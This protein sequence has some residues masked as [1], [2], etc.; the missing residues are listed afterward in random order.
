ML[1]IKTD[2]NNQID[3]ENKS[4]EVSDKVSA[5]GA[6][7]ITAKA[8]TEIKIIKAKAVKSVVSDDGEVELKDASSVRKVVSVIRGVIAKNIE[9]HS[10]NNSDSGS[11]SGSG[12]VSDEFTY[13]KT[14]GSIPKIF[15]HIGTSEHITR[16]NF[17]YE[18]A[19]N[20]AEIT[21]E[22]DQ[23][24]YDHL[25]VKEDDESCFVFVD[26]DGVERYEFGKYETSDYRKKTALGN[27][28]A[29]IYR[30]IP[31]KTIVIDTTGLTTETNANSI[32]DILA[33]N[34]K[35]AA[36]LADEKYNEYTD[37]NLKNRLEFAGI[38]VVSSDLVFN[39]D[40]NGDCLKPYGYDSFVHYS[41]ILANEAGNPSTKEDS[42]SSYKGMYIIEK[43]VQEGRALDLFV[44]VTGNE[45]ISY[46]N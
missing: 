23:W 43:A 3:I 45:T 9:A 11:G 5:D 6:V 38:T 27:F 15:F 12:A 42:S 31:D 13:T 28:Y 30:G 29:D 37:G 1:N 19:E 18:D 34:D 22:Q 41:A 4:I 40:W 44:D 20:D 7:T 33:G 24:I 25:Q 26:A 32:L 16:Q 8:P 10:R 39:N 14:P 36:E 35:L 46:N 17:S 2:S 21:N